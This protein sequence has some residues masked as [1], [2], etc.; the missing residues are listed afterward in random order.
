[1]ILDAAT[2]E[3]HIASWG[4]DEM[5]KQP[6]I[7][8][9]LTADGENPSR[10]SSALM[11]VLLERPEGPSLVLTQRAAH[12]PKHPGQ[13]SFPGGQAEPQ[14]PD[15]IATA[16][17]ETEEE[18]GLVVPRE[19]VLAALPRYATRTGFDVA[20]FVTLVQPPAFWVPQASEVAEVFEVPLASFL[21][22]G[23]WKRDGARFGGTKLRH[24]WAVDLGDRYLWGATAAMLQGFV[25]RLKDELA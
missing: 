17:R 19:R 7:G 9:D 14:D 15:L 12:L 21:Q 4:F 24:W 1:M 2:L 8:D 22:D 18:V 23:V 11:L 25:A 20:P 10:R 16:V 5:S 3:P 6:R 13:I